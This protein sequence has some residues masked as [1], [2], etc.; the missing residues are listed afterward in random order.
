M[1]LRYTRMAQ[2]LHWVVALAIPPMM[3]LGLYMEGLPFSP[4]KLQ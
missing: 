2:A 4:E 1:S 3:A